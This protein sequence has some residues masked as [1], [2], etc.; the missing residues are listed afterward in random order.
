VLYQA[1]DLVEVAADVYA[2]AAVRVLARLHYPDVLLIRVLLFYFFDFLIVLDGS[3]FLLHPARPLLVPGLITLR[4]IPIIVAVIVLRPTSFVPPLGKP[5]LVKDP[6]LFSFLLLRL[7]HVFALLISLLF[8]LLL[9]LLL[10]L[11]RPLLKFMS[12]ILFIPPDLIRNVLE[13]ELKPLEILI[14]RT[15]PRVDQEGQGQNV[16]GIL[17]YHVVVLSH[18]EEDALLVRELLILLYSIIYLYSLLQAVYPRRIQN[19]LRR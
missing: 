12:P 17:T 3:I 14:P 5:L 2:V 18:I 16:E 19:L 8:L 6:S 13:I 9:Q 1:P 10:D 11:F 4:L 7:N 15:P